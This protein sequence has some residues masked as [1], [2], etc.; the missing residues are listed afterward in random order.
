MFRLVYFVLLTVLFSCSNEKNTFNGKLTNTTEDEWIY[1]EKI[2]VTDIQKVDSSKIYDGNFQFNYSI[3]SI[4]FYRLTLSDDNFAI[5][6]LSKNDTVDFS[7]DARSLFNYSA[8]GS[9]EL[10][11][12]TKLFSIINNVRLKTDSL[13][14]VYQTAIGTED[15]NIVLERIRLKYEAIVLEKEKKVKNFIKSN[16]SLFT[17][18]IALQELGDVSVFYEYYKLVSDSLSVQYPNNQWVKDIIKKTNAVKNTAIGAIAPNFSINDKFGNN[19]IFSS[20]RGKLV[21]LD[22]WASW[23]VPCRKENPLIVDLYNE[24]KPKGLEIVGISLDDTTRNPNAKRDWL[25]AIEKD[26]LSWAQLSQ[27]N[28]FESSV[29][30]EYG[31]ESIPSTFL[32]DENGIII[33]RNLRGT[34]LHNKIKEILD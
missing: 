8:T 16:S 6:T 5:L 12:N 33:A 1:L 13:R 18:L 14:L 7:A 22:F 17:N 26:N 29:C 30:K 11:A 19:F 10:E 15:E 2:S 4:G 34:N 3:D 9:N 31:I 27:L 32:I 28:G 21:L 25:N 24:F 23:C 20:L